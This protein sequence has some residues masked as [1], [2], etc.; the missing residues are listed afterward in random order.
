M[1]NVFLSDYK[2]DGGWSIVNDTITPETYESNGQFKV[3]VP[4]D[5]TTTYYPGMPL[6][7]N[8]LS[9]Q[10]YAF[11]FNGSTRACTIDNAALRFTSSLTMECDIYLDSVTGTQAIY[12]RYDKTT[13]T[14]RGF[15]FYLIGAT[16][17]MVIYASSSVGTQ[18]QFTALDLTPYVGK[19]CHISFSYNTA[20]HVGTVSVNGKFQS[21]EANAIYNVIYSPT[22]PTT[23]GAVTDSAGTYAYYLD[24]RVANM[25]IWSGV[26]TPSAI[27]YYKD[28]ILAG[29]E[30]NLVAYWKFNNDLLD[31][32]TG[33]LTL[34]G[35]NTTFIQNVPE[36]FA[37]DIKQFMITNVVYVVGDAKTYLY[38]TA[39]K[40]SFVYGTAITNG[41][42]KP[43]GASQGTG[44]NQLNLYLND[45]HARGY[46]TAPVSLA[47]G[48]VLPISSST[49]DPLSLVDTTNFCINIPVS[50][51]YDIKW[52]GYLTQSASWSGTER[53]RI[54]IYGGAS[55]ICYGSTIMPPNNQACFVRTADTVYLQ[56]GT[57]VYG[58]VLHDDAGTREVSSGYLQTFIHINL[59]NV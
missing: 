35:V 14:K 8:Q 3:S 1:R 58:I 12:G 9:G 43:I 45:C 49:F 46:Y 11:N 59:I 37:Q 29:S 17:N 55:V 31:S 23:V 57:A 52:G 36:C 56:K 16:P 42:Y 39:D 25:R 51:Y 54:D 41:R 47:N 15:L 4:E 27:I 40:N 48:A 22:E 18:L 6:Q 50:G 24:G 19:W 21:I 33:G 30:T 7:F 10:S 53:F 13:T 44:Y 2:V 32:G 20:T 26:R 38:L 5:K 34:T 28:S